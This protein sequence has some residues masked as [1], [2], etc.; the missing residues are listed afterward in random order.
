MPTQLLKRSNHPSENMNSAHGCNSSISCLDHVRGHQCFTFKPFCWFSWYS[1]Y[2]C[3]STSGQNAR[4]PLPIRLAPLLV[5]WIFSLLEIYLCRLFLLM[6]NWTRSIFVLFGCLVVVRQ[7]FQLLFSRKLVPC[8]TLC[9]TRRRTRSYYLRACWTAQ[10]PRPPCLL[11]AQQQQQSQPQLYLCIVS[12]SH[13][14]S[15]R[16]EGR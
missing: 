12:H 2:S 11:M 3:S 8:T 16:R 6:P 5:F 9:L 7:D 1:R 14:L 4:L 15:K 10:Q 13:P